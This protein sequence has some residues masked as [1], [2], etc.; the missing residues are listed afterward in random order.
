MKLS[1]IFKKDELVSARSYSLPLMITA[2]N[3]ALAIYILISLYTITMNAQVTGEIA[4]QNFLRTYYIAAAVELLV[5]LLVTPS[6]TASAILNER[7]QRT[8]S[9]LLTTQLRPADIVIGKLMGSLSTVGMMLITSFPVF[10]T[11]FIYG[12]VAPV[13]ILLLFLTYAASSLFSAVVGLTSA[14]IMHGTA[15][16]TTVAYAVILLVYGGILLLFFFRSTIGLTVS[17][18]ILASVA[19]LLVTSVLMIFFCER[20]I[21]PSRPRKAR[22]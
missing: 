1:P 8:L 10:A 4:Y 12:G 7:E 2:V 14:T 21:Q 20:H 13:Q 11:V 22:K 3:A 9:L 5:I 18:L 17:A 15:M 6:L 16:T 19:F